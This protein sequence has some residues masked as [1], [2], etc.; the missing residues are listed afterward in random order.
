M[1]LKL[2]DWIC[3]AVRYML[4]PYQYPGK[5]LSL[6]G[7]TFTDRMLVRELVAMSDHRDWYLSN[8]FKTV[9]DVGAYIGAFA[10]AIHTILPEARIYSFEP[11]L[12]N[13]E[14]LVNN[15]EPAGHFR[16]FHTALG[17]QKGEMDFW[18]SDFTASSSA[19]PMADLHKDTFPH[20]SHATALKVPVARL[21]DYLPSMELEPPVL[22]K[23]DV[24]GFEDKVLLG[25]SE[26]LGKV[27]V[28][29]SEVSYKPLYE[30]QVLFEQIYARLGEH[31][32]EYAGN[33]DSLISPLDGTILQSDALFVCKTK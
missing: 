15:L 28:V 2:S 11:L 23:I 10:Y 14:K 25:G 26:T 16:A 29:L 33:F 9:I 22:L 13:Y 27:N 18:K 8:N 21:D 12:E 19:L 17:D 4:F 30:G 24:Q 32:F 7:K 3:K 31:G 1:G 5:T 20:T 6:I